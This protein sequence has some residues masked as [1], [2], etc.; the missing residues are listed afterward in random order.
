MPR[1]TTAFSGA[2]DLRRQAIATDLEPSVHITSV[3]QIRGLRPGPG[4]GWGQAADKPSISLQ[5]WAPT[6]LTSKN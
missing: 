1:M 3:A 5:A 6:S 4:L 2:S